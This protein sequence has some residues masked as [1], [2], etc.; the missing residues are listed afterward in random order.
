MIKMEL[1]ANID[2]SAVEEILRKAIESE[3]G[4]KVDRVKFTIGSRSDFHDRV[5]SSVFEGCTVFFKNDNL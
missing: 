1:S 2:A 5:T 4:F 3:T